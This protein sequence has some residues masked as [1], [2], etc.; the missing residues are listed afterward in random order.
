MIVFGWPEAFFKKK[1]TTKL[2]MTKLIYKRLQEKI[3]RSC[4]IRTWEQGLM[5]A[6][7]DAISCE[8]ISED[9][10][11]LIVRTK[12]SITDPI[13]SLYLEDLDWECTCKSNSD[14]CSHV[15]ASIIALVRSSKENKLPVSKKKQAILEYHF[16]TR[17]DGLLLSRYFVTKKD[18]ELLKRPLL[19]GLS[20]R[21]FPFDYKPTKMDLDADAIIGRAVHPNRAL[22]AKLLTML[23]P[24]LEGCQQVFFNKKKINITSDPILPQITV[25]PEQELGILLC[26]K[27]NPEVESIPAAGI[28]ICDN[29]IHPLG[30][31]EICGN[32]FEKLPRHITYQKKDLAEFVSDVL[33]QLEKDNFVDI[34]TPLP[35][36]SRFLEPR[37][38]MNME[39]NAGLVFIRPDLVYGNPPHVI[40]KKDRM[41][42]IEGTIPIRKKD[43]ERELVENLRHELNLVTDRKVEF[44]KKDALV[45][46]DKFRKWSQETLD[47]SQHTI[48]NQTPLSPTVEINENSF[49][50]YFSIDT[51]NPTTGVRKASG[52]NVLEAWKEGLELA[53]LEG[54]GF[55]P[56]PLK[57][58]DLHGHTILD[59]LDSKTNENQIN[60]A[61]IPQVTKLAKDLGLPTPPGFSHLAKSFEAFESIP[62]APLS[63]NLKNILRPYQRQGVNWLVF[64]RSMKLGAILADDM[65]LGKTIQALSAIE[66]KTLVVCPTSV[67]HNWTIETAKFR[68][69]LKVSIFHGPQREIDSHADIIVTNYAL[70]RIE[71]TKL[72]SIKWN[73]IIMDEAQNIK[74]PQSQAAKAACNL[75]GDFKVALS[76]TPVENKLEELWSISEF[77]NPGFL[78]TYKNFQKRFALPIAANDTT[79]S[80]QLKTKIKPFV[81]RRKKA[82]VEPD[83]PSRTTIELECELNE[84]E[85]EIYDALR[86]TANKEV[87]SM[88]EK[89]KGVMAILEQLLR[90]RQAAC[91]PALVPGC[92]AN[93]SSK[94]EL[95]IYELLTSIEN[96]HKALVFSQWTSLLNLVEPHFKANSITFCRLDGQT[97]N[98]E[99]V[100]RDFQ[101]NSEIKVMLISLKA[102]G[103]GLN[104]TAADHVYML[105]PWWNPAV[106]DQAAD[107]THRIGQEKPVFVYR[108]V[109]QNTVEEKILQLQERKRSIALAALGDAAQATA[110]TKEELLAL[111]E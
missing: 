66:G 34:K 11:E 52:L 101:E 109:A 17:K 57:W 83:L 61:V 42:Y 94:I 36:F 18:K 104:L 40:I 88:L 90:L 49:N 70:L 103:T 54:G 25:T 105:D 95:L 27:P 71:R 92:T 91:H 6:G 22:P 85:R 99:Q 26:L 30:Q 45:F 31:M 5:L 87:V 67:L 82:Q 46:L 7:E 16:S 14:N 39:Q 32:S 29:T 41:E 10:V 24:R 69:D 4:G 56:I 108:L 55:A 3:K 73:T 12:G 44:A 50:L 80:E 63:E 65:G 59:I 77:T 93:G 20:N 79:A 15:A 37:L 100:V 53:P 35:A 107:R 98:R 13:V 81:L 78:G 21:K 64:L 51:E 75:D 84:R 47:I 111:L 38:V 43:Q 76:G 72:T 74:N 106:E 68:P 23:I 9:Q 48:S 110:I 58:L 96:E 60:H 62:E 1:W 86:L 89:G 2:A 97:K 33:P 8:S 19:M 102:G 28:A